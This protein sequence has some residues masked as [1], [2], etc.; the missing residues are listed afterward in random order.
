MSSTPP[1]LIDR[2]LVA[3]RR[4]RAISKGDP[5]A[6]VLLNWVTEDIGDR[7]A[8]LLRTF[9]RGVVLGDP[10]GGLTRTVAASGRVKELI[11]ADWLVPGLPDQPAAAGVVDDE[12]LPYE[13]NSLDLFVSALTLQFANDLPGALIQIRRA[14]RPD[15][16]MLASLL[17]G[18]TLQELRAVL[19][20]AEAD[21]TG[22][23][24]PRIVPFA[25]I[26]D[27]GALL[28]RAGFA[29]P[30]TDQDRLTLRYPNAFAL[31]KDLA[32]MGAT[33]PLFER[34]RGFTARAVFIRAVELYQSRYC[35][36][37]G[38]VRATFTLLSASGWSP[39]ES[40]QKPLKPGSATVSLKDVLERK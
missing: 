15:G 16:L 32:R 37:D 24:T 1:R 4:A 2:R 38:R 29:L 22:G 39:H 31:M 34:H 18:D 14:L 10:T 40:Q 20:E 33:N 35:D 21:I 5:S 12:H 3:Q 7:L 27:I 23:T 30:V 8:T 25:D 19:L 28:Q 26:R 36:E 11:R 9:E 13:P 6:L 17:G